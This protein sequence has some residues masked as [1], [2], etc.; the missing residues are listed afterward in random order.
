MAELG[1]SSGKPAHASYTKEG[2][3]SGPEFVGAKRV[4][5]ELNKGRSGAKRTVIVQRQIVE[6]VVP[7]PVYQ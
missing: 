7:V 2:T 6:K 4:I 3:G 1:D 5:P